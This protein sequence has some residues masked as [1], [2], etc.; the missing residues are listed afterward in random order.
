MTPDERFA[1]AA[2]DAVR[3]GWVALGARGAGRFAM[4]GDYFDDWQHSG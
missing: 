3:T 4:Q 1:R 2:L